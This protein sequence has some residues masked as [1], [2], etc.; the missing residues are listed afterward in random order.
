MNIKKCIALLFLVAMVSGCST[1]APPYQA[2]LLVGNELKDV[3]FADMKSGDFS[4]EEVSVN[5]V[6]LRG[7]RMSSPYSNSYAEYLKKGLEEELKLASLWDENSNTVINAV[8]T[9]N[10]VDAS[11]T[12]IG[13][14]D[15]AADFNVVRSEK[16]IYEKTHKI[17]HEW[18][19]SFMGNI[20]I[21]NAH[22]GYQEAVKILLDAFFDDPE[23]AAALSGEE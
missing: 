9:E 12:S 2:G 7:G 19:S 8:L 13:T 1:M 20:A 5:N 16:T 3:E 10:N 22:I 11:G 21:P 17:H 23:L 15:L 14:A 4:M 6:T 18:E